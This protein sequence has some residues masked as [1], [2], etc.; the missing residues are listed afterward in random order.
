MAITAFRIALTNL[1][2]PIDVEWQT[3]LDNLQKNSRRVLA[4]AQ[5]TDAMK[6]EENRKCEYSSIGEWPGI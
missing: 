6:T 2:K 5:A 3:C 1:V 4:L